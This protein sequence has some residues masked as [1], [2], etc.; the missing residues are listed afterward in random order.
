MI[1]LDNL[2]ETVVVNYVLNNKTIPIVRAV[3]GSCAIACIGCSAV[4][5]PAEQRVGSRCYRCYT[6]AKGGRCCIT[7][8]KPIQGIYI[9]CWNCKI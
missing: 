1:L 6:E 8:H 3:C 4:I 7:C 2:V 9:R 5:G